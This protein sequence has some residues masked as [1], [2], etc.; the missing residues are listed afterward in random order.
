MPASC[1]GGARTRPIAVGGGET[2]GQPQRSSVRGRAAQKARW[3]LVAA[4][5]EHEREV[6]RWGARRRLGGG[7]WEGSPPGEGAVRRPAATVRSARSHEGIG[8]AA[9]SGAAW[10]RVRG[11]VR[12]LGVEG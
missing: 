6:R 11:E 4:R 8:E 5:V 10:E 2:C 7:S 12:I 1:G 3:P 9:G